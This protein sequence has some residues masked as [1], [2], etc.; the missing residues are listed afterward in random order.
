MKYLIL[1]ASLIATTAYGASQQEID[2]TC[3]LE[4]AR[5][6]VTASVL[7]A[8]YVYGSVSNASNDNGVSLGIGYSF[9]GKSRAK[10]LRDAAESRCMA[11]GAT[12]ELDE[13]QRWL[14]ASINKAG[15]R[16]ELETL[17]QARARSLEQLGFIRAQLKAQTVTLAEYNAA[18]QAQQGIEARIAQLRLVLAE[19]TQPTS[20][21][22]V[23]SLL[24]VAKAQTTRAAELEARS[25]ADAAWD[26][27]IV[28]GARADIDSIKGGSTPKQAPAPYIGLTF[29]WSFGAAG[30]SKAVTTVKDR[31]EQLFVISKAGYVATADRLLEQVTEALKIEQD[32]EASVAAQLRETETL[33]ISF[34]TLDTALAL[35]TKRTLEL[36]ALMQQGELAGIQKR[37]IEYRTFIQRS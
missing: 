22:S 18:R 23:R 17:V 36:Q 14:L 11:M 21:K 3:D 25:S 7:A 5:A 24:E 13:Q 33:L 28:A 10:L 31:T 6:E 30:A 16:A 26:V 19:P 8:P 32:R 37:I 35:N 12:L 1:I 20:V 34:R 27:S 2:V 4:K 29:R 15:A 9:A